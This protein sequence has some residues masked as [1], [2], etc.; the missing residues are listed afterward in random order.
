MERIVK[1]ITGGATRRV[2]IIA[3]DDGTFSFAEET[4][5]EH[6]H[7]QSWVR[8]RTRVATICASAENAEREARRR[9]DLLAAGNPPGAS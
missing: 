7:E 6:P 1:T 3:R 2:L 8:T 5:S 4:F 9:I